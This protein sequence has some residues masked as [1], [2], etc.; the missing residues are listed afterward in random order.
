MDI[1]DYNLPW[2]AIAE[3]LIG[4]REGGNPTIVKW[5]KELGGSVGAYYTNDSIPWCGLFVAHCLYRAGVS[6]K[7]VDNPLWALDWAGFGDKTE[8][9][10]GAIMAFGRDGGGHVAFYVSEDDSYYHTLGGN[11]SDMVNITRIAKS[12]LVD[13]RFPSGLDHLKTP[14]RIRK[15]FDGQISENEV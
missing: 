7:E 10:F 12:R 13:S 3:R 14:G 15:Q 6:I 5:A 4:T 9:C 2:I 1:R 11:Q 8:P